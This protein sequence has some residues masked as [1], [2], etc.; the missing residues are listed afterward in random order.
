MKNE[1]KREG[2]IF[3]VLVAHTVEVHILMLIFTLKINVSSI[4][5][6]SEGRD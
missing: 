2:G 4:K 1:G 6:R 3:T 5:L